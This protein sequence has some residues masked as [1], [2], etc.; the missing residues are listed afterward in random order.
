M[1][2]GLY[3]LR[4]HHHWH[5]GRASSCNCSKPGSRSSIRSWTCCKSRRRRWSCSS[6]LSSVRNPRPRP[7]ARVSL[8]ALSLP[9][10]RFPCAPAAAVRALRG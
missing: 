3:W 5:C 10:A 6:A 8:Y 9:M 4:A 2:S 7:I 1:Q